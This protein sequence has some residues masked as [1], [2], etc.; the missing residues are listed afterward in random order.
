MSCIMI[1]SDLCLEGLGLSLVGIENLEVYVMK[2]CSLFRGL[3]GQF[4]GA[5]KTASTLMIGPGINS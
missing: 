1:I 3:E 2:L 5:V 4:G